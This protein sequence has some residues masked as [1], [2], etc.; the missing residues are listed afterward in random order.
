MELDDIKKH[1]DKNAKSN[2]TS[3]FSTT[4]TPT[5]K[6]LEIDAFYRA[7][8]NLCDTQKEGHLLEVGCGNGYNLF[9]LKQ[10]LPNLKFQGVDYSADMINAAKKINDKQYN[11][12]IDFSIADALKLPNSKLQ[13]DAY[14]F[15][16]TDRMLINLNSW[17]LQR[18]ALRNISELLTP[19]G[20]L[21]V[22]ENFVN[23]YARQNELRELIGLPSRTPDPYNKFLDEN[24]FE[25]FV[26][27]SIGLEI[28]KIDNFASLHDILLYVLLPHRNS[29]AISYDDPLMNSVAELLVNLPN[30]HSGIFG[31]FGQ[32][33]LYVLRRA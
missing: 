12:E 22:I 9:G 2:T 13:R 24:L 30:E 23:P 14:D 5:I 32:N 26:T 3:I 20:S 21:L 29:G 11:S 33:N 10:L 28:L 27:E 15:V 25:K 19:G 4:K 6:K 18:E 17:T 31:N 1:W 16:I 8:L 7:I